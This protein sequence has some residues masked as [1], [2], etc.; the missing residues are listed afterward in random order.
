MLTWMHW[1]CEDLSS[2]LSLSSNFWGF[3]ERQSPEAYLDSQPSPRGKHQVNEGPVFKNK[4]KGVSGAI[5]KVALW[6]P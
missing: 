2:N 1:K 6:L 3:N 5:P 4:V